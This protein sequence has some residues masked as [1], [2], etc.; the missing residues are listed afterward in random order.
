MLQ[1]YALSSCALTC[2]LLILPVA[3][4]PVVEVV[5]AG[6]REAH[7]ADHEGENAQGA[8]EQQRDLP[9]VEAL[10]CKGK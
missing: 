7:A 3:V 5:G 2:A 8:G 4:P 1:R 6:T 9:G 10:L